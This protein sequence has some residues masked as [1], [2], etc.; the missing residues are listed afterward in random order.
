MNDFATALE[1]LHRDIMT[2][3]VEDGRYGIEDIVFAREKFDTGSATWARDK[4][5]LDQHGLELRGKTTVPDLEVYKRLNAQGKLVIVT[6]RVD[7][8]AIGYCVHMVS[9]DIHFGELIAM[10]DVTF[11]APGLRRLG[12]GRRLREKAIE[13]LK[14]MG[15]KVVLARFKVAH[16]HDEHM[17]KMGFV[18]YETVYVKEI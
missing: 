9:K 5:L 12:I 10:D 15:V 13:E 4:E 11:V 18:P 3:H 17:K 16:P 14:A 7:N 6:A 2:I 8:L 1:S